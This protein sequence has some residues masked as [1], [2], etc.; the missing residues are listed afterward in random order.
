MEKQDCFKW[1]LG[2]MEMGQNLTK[3]MNLFFKDQ[4]TS[5]NR[6]TRAVL[7]IN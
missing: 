5:L 1:I 3:I 2:C 7:G 4:G 6:G